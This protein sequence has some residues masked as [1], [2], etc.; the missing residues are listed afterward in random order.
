MSMTKYYKVLW[1]EKEGKDKSSIIGLAYTEEGVIK[2][3][4]LKGSALPVVPETLDFLEKIFSELREAGILKSIR[5]KYGGYVLAKDPKNLK[6]SEIVKVLDNPLQS[7]DCITGEYQLEI[8]C[9]VEFVW[10]RVHNAMILELDKLTLQDI[11]DYGTAVAN[12]E[13]AKT[14]DKESKVE[15]DS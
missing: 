7:Y 1:Q 15:I 4:W 5:G 10:K 13:R 8:N 9:A 6:L 14:L 11:I 2:V 3:R 12:L